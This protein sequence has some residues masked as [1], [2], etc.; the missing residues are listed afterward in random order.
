MSRE[1]IESALLAAYILA[2]TLLFIAMLCA[3]G[4][5]CTHDLSCPATESAPHGTAVIVWC[6]ECK[7]AVE[8]EPA[9]RYAPESKPLHLHPRTKKLLRCWHD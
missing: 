1:C 4:C 7:Q 9:T 2:V 3:A 5:A 8:V 6:E